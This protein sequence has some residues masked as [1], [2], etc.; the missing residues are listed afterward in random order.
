MTCAHYPSTRPEHHADLLD[1]QLIGQLVD[2]AGVSGLQLTGEGGLLQQLTKRLLEWALEGEITDHV[3]YE[4]HDPVGAGSGNS[5]NGVRS[6]TVLTDVGP[7]EIDVHTNR[8]APLA[9]QI[10][11]AEP[12]TTVRPFWA[13]PRPRRLPKRPIGFAAVGTPG[14]SVVGSLVSLTAFL[15][16]SVCAA[17]SMPVTL[18]CSI[19]ETRA[20]ELA[21]DRLDGGTVGARLVRGEAGAVHQRCSRDGLVWRPMYVD[22]ALYKP[23]GVV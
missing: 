16:G 2:R 21:I 11:A 3:G 18:P 19:W 22:G 8:V 17:V 7:V 4:K 10:P 20:W 13:P 6:K 5:G 14:F 15:A 12:A 1:D 23:C 9:V